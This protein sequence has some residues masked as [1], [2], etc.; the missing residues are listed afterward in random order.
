LVPVTVP[1][2]EWI[3]NV[4]LK[5]I[6][7]S[8][9]PAPP[10]PAGPSVYVPLSSKVPGYGPVAT[11]LVTLKLT[12]SVLFGCGVHEV[13]TVPW[14]ALKHVNPEGGKAEH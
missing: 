1:A 6:T 4:E 13:V 10:L 5:A 3:V 8:P 9:T 2:D 7:C 12:I 14:P 11:P